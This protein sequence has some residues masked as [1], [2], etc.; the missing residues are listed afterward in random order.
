MKLSKKKLINFKMNKNVDTI[1]T[2][3]VL[4]KTGI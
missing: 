4:K 3:K 1:R 2:K